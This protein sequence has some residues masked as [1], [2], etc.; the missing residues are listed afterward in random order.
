MNKMRVSSYSTVQYI[1]FLPLFHIG[2]SFTN[3]NW[4]IKEPVPKRNACTLLVCVHACAYGTDVVWL[5]N[6][7]LFYLNVNILFSFFFFKLVLPNPVQFSPFIVCP[8]C[9]LLSKREPYIL[10][11]YNIL[12]VFPRIVPYF[13]FP[14]LSCRHFQ[15]SSLCLSLKGRNH[16][17]P[18]EKANIPT[19]HVRLHGGKP[20]TR[21]K[22]YYPCSKGLLIVFVLLQDPL[23]S[24]HIE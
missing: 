11:L 9:Y 23:L 17:L 22:I 8:T 19:I 2:L 6:C 7:S 12:L 18:A 21:H 15:S 3:H 1:S 14:Q 16:F 10:F 5:N 20:V 4:P 24:V 13:P